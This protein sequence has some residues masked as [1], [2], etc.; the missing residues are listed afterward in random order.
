MMEVVVVVVV[1]GTFS[2]FFHLMPAV[3]RK[4]PMAVSCFRAVCAALC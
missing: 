1:E 2:F 3:D 4:T